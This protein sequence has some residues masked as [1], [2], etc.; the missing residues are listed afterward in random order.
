MT[1]VAPLHRLALFA[2]S[3]PGLATNA[4]LDGG[5]A[6]HAAPRRMSS[7]CRFRH[8]GLS[9]L[10]ALEPEDAATAITI[11]ARVGQVPYTAESASA[12]LAVL[13]ALR[14]ARGLP[15]A[16]F[17]IDQGQAIWLTSASVVDGPLA[18][19]TVMVELL[20]LIGEARPYLRI[21][22]EFL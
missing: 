12:R 11:R 19:E 18:P 17:G 7:Q 16:R 9:Y 13:T 8:D 22:R 21:L 14:H 20:R 10:V 6:Q 3:V 2:E 5:D 15:V 1:S 4:F